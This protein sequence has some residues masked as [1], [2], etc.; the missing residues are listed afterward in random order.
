MGPERSDCRTT[1]WMAEAVGIEPLFPANT[2]PMMANDF[3]FYDMKAFEL[4]RRF[5][6]PGVPYSP[7]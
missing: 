6:S 4:P 3:G 7:L 5:F 1:A 2:S